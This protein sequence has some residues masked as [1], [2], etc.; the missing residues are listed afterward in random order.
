M[1]EPKLRFKEDELD[2]FLEIQLWIHR[3]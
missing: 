3:L 1:Y 2:Q